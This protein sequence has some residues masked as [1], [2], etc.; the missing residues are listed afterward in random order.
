MKEVENS[1]VEG[2]KFGG[3]GGRGGVR[4]DVVENGVVRGPSGFERED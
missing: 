2:P 1:T 4:V 3:R